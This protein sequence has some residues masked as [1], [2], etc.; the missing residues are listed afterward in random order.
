MFQ[1]SVTHWKSAYSTL[2]GC[3]SIVFKLDAVKPS[4]INIIVN[5]ILV[6][7]TRRHVYASFMLTQISDLSK[8]IYS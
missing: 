4:K 5:E 6:T 1:T 2:L 3:I 8:Y 7:E